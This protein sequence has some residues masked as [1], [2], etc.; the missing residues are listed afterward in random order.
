M[1]G[2]F[3]RKGVLNGTVGR[4]NCENETERGKPGPNERNV[5]KL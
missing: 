2:R 4:W 3:L 1:Y 5:D